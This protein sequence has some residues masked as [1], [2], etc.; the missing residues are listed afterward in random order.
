[1]SGMPPKWT[2]LR[3]PRKLDQDSGV[4]YRD[5][6]AVRYPDHPIEPAVEAIMKANQYPKQ[7]DSRI[8]IV[9]CSSTL[10]N[11][12]RFA[13][14]EHHPCRMLVE[15]VGNTVHLIRRE[16]SPRQIIPNVWGYGHTFPEAY[17]S[18]DPPVGGSACH[19][20]IMRY[21]F[22]GLG[23]IVRFGADGY[24]P[25]KAG[26]HEWLRS[27]GKG[28]ESSKVEIDLN[29]LGELNLSAG[30][31]SVPADVSAENESRLHISVAGSSVPQKA[32]FDLKTRSIRRKVEEEEI[33]NSELPRLWLAQIPNLILAYHSFGTFDEIEIIDVNPVVTKWVSEKESEL[34]RFGLLLRKIVDIARK[35]DNGKLEIVR[36]ENE[37][38]LQVREQTPDVLPA[39]SLGTKKR[40]ERW[41]AGN[42]SIA[43]HGNTVGSEVERGAIDGSS[44]P[45]DEKQ[46]YTACDDECGYCG[47]CV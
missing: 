26:A 28:E 3:L 41:L 27:K 35:K 19:Q 44:D 22:G 6:N 21:K 10:G 13:R 38:F 4:Y 39:L 12:L 24:L 45:S 2:P 1:M 33:I 9:A 25:E 42:S 11:L 5:Q 29:S 15:V 14:G 36:H 17:T 30:N 34:R 32:V 20:R 43:K 23:C 47:H 31:H 8:D 18:W 7:N 37:D 46:D 16:N 40:W